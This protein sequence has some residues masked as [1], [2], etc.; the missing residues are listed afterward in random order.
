MPR[1][2]VDMSPSHE[3]SGSKENVRRHTKLPDMKLKRRRKRLRYEDILETFGTDEVIVHAI[4]VETVVEPV[5]RRE[6]V[7]I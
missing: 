3:L 4:A 2:V 1:R 6:W 5:S 7:L